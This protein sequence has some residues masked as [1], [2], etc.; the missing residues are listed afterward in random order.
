MGDYIT[1]RTQLVFPN[2]NLFRKYLDP[3]IS[4]PEKD[5][6]L[7]LV[8]VESEKWVNNL[9]QGMTAIPAT[10]IRTELK[11]VALEYA[12][13]LILRDNYIF[14]KNDRE[15]V[16]GLYLTNAKEL[17]SNLRYPASASTPVASSQNVGNGTITNVIIESDYTLTE[18]WIVRAVNDHVWEVIGSCSGVLFDYDTNDG[19]Y[20]VQSEEDRYYGPMRRVSFRITPGT[21]AFACTD[22][23][24][25]N[26]YKASWKGAPAYSLDIS[27]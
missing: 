12:R 23:F 2:G 13:Y 20:P 1:N 21:T 16:S 7:D 15:P 26:T 10:H 4:E 24:T 19:Y 3:D 17:V 8:I 27:R 22:E 25:F 5:A 9:L 6:A 14:E 18:S 11:Q